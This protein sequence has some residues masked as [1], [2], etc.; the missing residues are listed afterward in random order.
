LKRIGSG[1]S[2]DFQDDAFLFEIIEKSANADAIP[3][4][5]RTTPKK[6]KNQLIMGMAKNIEVQKGVASI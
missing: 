6:Q 2:I 1:R 5:F 3:P 4:L